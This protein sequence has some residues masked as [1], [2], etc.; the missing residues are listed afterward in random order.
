[1]LAT[2]LIIG[3]L[4]TAAIV[5]VIYVISNTNG[6]GYEL[7]AFINRG[8]DTYYEVTLFNNKKIEWS[9]I[10]DVQ[11]YIKL[12]SVFN[13]SKIDGEKPFKTCEFYSYLKCDKT[14]A[15]KIRFYLDKIY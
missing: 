8:R 13:M 15:S 14:T 2:I 1:M 6:S 12:S 4:L 7:Y 11:Q 9:E 3:T 10:L 5:F